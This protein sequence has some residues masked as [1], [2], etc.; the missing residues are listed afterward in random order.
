ML[1]YEIIRVGIPIRQE[2][3]SDE[4][5]QV[6]NEINNDSGVLGIVTANHS[7]GSQEYENAPAGNRLLPVDKLV[8]YSFIWGS[9]KSRDL[10]VIVKNLLDHLDSKHKQL[11]FKKVYMFA[12]GSPNCSDSLTLLIGKNRPIKV[13]DTV[14][15]VELAMAE[16]KTIVETC[17][18]DIR[19]YHYDFILKDRKYVSPNTLSIW[20]C[21]QR[22]YEVNGKSILEMFLADMESLIGSDALF[23]AVNIGEDTNTVFKETIGTARQN[24][25]KFYDYPKSL[26]FGTYNGILR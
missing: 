14:S 19:N 6:I 13:I 5:L 2:S 7:P 3:V 9:S 22:G 25:S 26:V 8:D 24:V 10:N 23:L 15:S 21:L 17:A 11:N 20:T 18:V 12:S 4:F 1:P 16:F